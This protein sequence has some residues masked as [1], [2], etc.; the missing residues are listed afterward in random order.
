VLHNWL[1]AN[2]RSITLDTES[3]RGKAIA[4]ALLGERN[5]LVTTPGALG[6]E[7]VMS[8]NPSL[9]VT[10]I[11]PFGCSGPYARY[12]ANDLTLFAMSGFSYYLAAPVR[13]PSAT[14]PKANPGRQ[15]SLVAGLRAASATL[16]GVAASRRKDAGLQVD[17]SEL[18]A[19]TYLMY[20]Y[21][22]HVA[23]HSLPVDRRQ[24]PG[25]VIT[26]VGGLVWCLPCSDGWIMVS[27]REDHQFKSWSEVIE[28]PEWHTRPEFS[29]AARR[30]ENAWAIYEH[31]AAWTRA[32]TKNEVFLAAQAR[33]VACFP[34]SRMNDLPRLAQLEHRGFFAPIDHPVIKGLNYP[35]LPVRID[36]R[37]GSDTRPAPM[38]G[39]HTAE[40][41]AALGVSADTL[42][43]LCGSGAS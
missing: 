38:L 35:S 6:I 9:T 19:F 7:D 13:D 27:P 2:K 23:N 34:I 12:V 18:E 29:T 31:S 41:C 40:V 21:T 20:Q 39:Q 36:G 3:A 30:E 42:A 4:R 5:V 10:T 15:V 25:A 22:A 43:A 1:C 17:V 33:R 32:R 16:W 37:P 8:I 14:P 26:I 24:V 28:Q 11:S